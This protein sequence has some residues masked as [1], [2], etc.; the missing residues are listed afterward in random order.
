MVGVAAGLATEGFRPFVYS[1]ATFATLRCLE[2][3][4]DDICYNNLPVT[5]VGVGVRGIAV[6]GAGVGFCRIFT[7]VGTGLG[8]GTAVAVGTG[9]GVNSGVGTTVGSGVAVGI[10]VGI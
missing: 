10:G 7:A 6:A 8:V 9:L 5:V 3:I 1:I 2:Q 4:R